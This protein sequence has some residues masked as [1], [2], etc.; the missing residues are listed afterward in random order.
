M[1]QALLLLLVPVLLVSITRDT[2]IVA[3]IDNLT[4]A[5]SP[6]STANAALPGTELVVGQ[7][8]SLEVAG[9]WFTYQGKPL[10]LMGSGMESIYTSDSV[11]SPQESLDRWMAYLDL[12]ARYKVNMVRFYAWAF[13]WDDT[14]PWQGAG[15]WPYTSLDPPVYD[16][17]AF[18]EPYW[19]TVRELAK[20]ASDRDIVLEYVLFEG[21][22][23]DRVWPKHPWNIQ[24]GGP[25][26]NK[27]DF[28]DLRNPRNLYFQ[29]R[30]VQKVLDELAG[31][32]NI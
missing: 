21:W 8:S 14:E 24:M 6:R 11:S 17:D 23:N 29:E 27:Q 3:P 7:G 31:M 15:P 4:P 13:V 9:Y 2:A 5:A 26:R 20:A 1:K 10:Y 19:E 28:F 22:L 32:P 12:L 25:L 30:Y 16:L 18:S